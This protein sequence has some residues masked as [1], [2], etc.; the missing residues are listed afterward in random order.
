MTRLTDQ[1]LAD[2]EKCARARYTVVEKPDNDA[3]HIPGFS[4]YLITPKGI[5]FSVRRKRCFIVTPQID[6]R[7]YLKLKLAV[8][9]TKLKGIFLHRALMLTFRYEQGCESLVV[10]HIDGNPLNNTLSN[11]RWTTH[12]GNHA[13][14]ERLGRTRKLE[15][16]GQSRLTNENV[17]EARRLYKSGALNLSDL[18]IKY[19]ISRASISNA[20]S[21]ETWKTLSDY[22]RGAE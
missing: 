7:G 14:R 21:G 11:L 5:V 3:L 12:K 9:T 20:V 10:D 18:A 8:S 15:K 19:G 16:H 4:G 22:E 6:A 13:N 2:A 1:E 17:R